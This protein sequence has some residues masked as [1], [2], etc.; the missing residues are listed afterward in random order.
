MRYDAA[1]ARPIPPPSQ[2]TRYGLRPPSQTV[3]GDQR[4]GFA[5]ARMS[6]R[7]PPFQMGP[8]RTP[9][10]ESNNPFEQ[11]W[12]FIQDM[13]RQN[14]QRQMAFNTGGQT[15]PAAW[16]QLPRIDFTKALQAATS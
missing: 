13:Q 10:G 11:R 4:G 6:D 15:R 5:S 8:A 2:G 14:M 7:P 12:K 1:A 9:W 3:T 16:G